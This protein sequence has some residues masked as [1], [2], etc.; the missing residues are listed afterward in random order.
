MRKYICDSI[1]VVALLFNSGLYFVNK[2][3]NISGKYWPYIAWFG[4]GLLFLALF[5]V[6][7]DK[8]SI[9]K[10]KSKVENTLK[11]YRGEILWLKM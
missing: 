9:K 11:K 1:L 2:Y 3:Y 8:N 4:I 5:L 10:L 7:L 6:T